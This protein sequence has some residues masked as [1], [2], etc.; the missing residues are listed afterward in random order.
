MKPLYKFLL[1][2]LAV[3]IIANFLWSIAVDKNIKVEMTVEVIE[4]SPHQIERKEELMKQIKLDHQEMTKEEVN[5]TANRLRMAEERIG[6][7][8][9]TPTQQVDPVAVRQ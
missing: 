8:R 7:T 4:D 2:A 5:Q 1:I 9:S 6:K 3:F